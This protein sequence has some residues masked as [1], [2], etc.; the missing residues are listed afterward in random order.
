MPLS[1][2]P[3]VSYLTC[4]KRSYKLLR[5]TAFIAKFTDSKSLYSSPKS[6]ASSVVE[7]VSGLS[8][9]TTSF[10]C[11]AQAPVLSSPRD[12][13]RLCFVGDVRATVT[14][15]SLGQSAWRDRRIVATPPPRQYGGACSRLSVSRVGGAGHA[16]SCYSL[17]LLH[18]LHNFAFNFNF[19][20]LLVSICLQS[21]FARFKLVFYCLKM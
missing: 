17:V 2:I 9:L 8:C 11:S 6:Q 10:P 3:D 14:D 1:G 20:L 13:G 12:T 4:A 7:T 15:G 19:Q 16:R 21:A 18:S 5:R